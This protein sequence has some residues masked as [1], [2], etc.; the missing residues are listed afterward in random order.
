MNTPLMDRCW[1]TITNALNLHM[2]AAPTGPAGTGKSESIKDL[3]RTLA[4]ICIVFN[5]SD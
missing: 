3:A 5:C 2:G 1:L 4:R